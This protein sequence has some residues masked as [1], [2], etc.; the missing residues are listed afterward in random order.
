MESEG[1]LRSTNEPSLA[2]II[3]YIN[4]P[5]TLPSILILSS[6]LRP[7]LPIGVFPSGFSIETLYAYLF[8]STYGTF[9]AHSTVLI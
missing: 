3:S 7:D 2:P 5:P 4:P 6:R 1:S 8:G 9:P